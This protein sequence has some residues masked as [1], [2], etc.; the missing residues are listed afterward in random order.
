MWRARTTRLFDHL[1][2]LLGD[3]D[4]SRRR[5][6]RY[7]C[8]SQ[9]LEVVHRQQFRLRPLNL[10]AGQRTIT[11]RV[12]PPLNPLLGKEPRQHRANDARMSDDG[13]SLIRMPGQDFGERR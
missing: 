10:Q 8:G 13:K 7:D 12:E 2:Y 4:A 1:L 9:V 6:S 3:L 5:L 11:D